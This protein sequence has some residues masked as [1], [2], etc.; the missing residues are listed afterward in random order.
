[1]VVKAIKQLNDLGYRLRLTLAG[2]E[3]SAHKLVEKVPLDECDARHFV[4]CLGHIDKSELPNSLAEFQYFYL[5][6]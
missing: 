5:C 3:G 1:M 2:A 4:D 6:I